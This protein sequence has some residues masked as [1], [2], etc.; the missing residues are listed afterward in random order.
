MP[1]TVFNKLTGPTIITNKYFIYF[2]YY[3]FNFGCEQSN[4][5]GAKDENK[6]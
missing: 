3:Y 5:K 6:N 2:Y 1:L 4:Y